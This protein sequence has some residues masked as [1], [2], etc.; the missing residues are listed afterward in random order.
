MFS[1]QWGN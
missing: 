1:W